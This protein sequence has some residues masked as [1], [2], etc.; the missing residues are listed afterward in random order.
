MEF[1]GQNLLEFGLLSYKFSTC[2]LDLFQYLGQLRPQSFLRLD[3]FLARHERRNR[4]NF[5]IVQ[6]LPM[7]PVSTI[8]SIDKRSTSFLGRS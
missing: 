6:I 4:S 3:A 1:T 5:T 8:S 2:M 7:R